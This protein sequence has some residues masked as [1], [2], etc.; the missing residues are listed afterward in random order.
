MKYMF[1]K[2]AL[3]TAAM[4][5][6]SREASAA[7]AASPFRTPVR[8][9]Y[10]M[11]VRQFQS[12]LNCHLMDSSNIAI[13]YKISYDFS[14]QS[15]DYRNWSPSAKQ[16]LGQ[17]F[18][19]TILWYESGMNNYPGPLVQDPPPN[20]EASA[21]AAGTHATTVYDN[22]TAL[23]PLYVGRVALILAAEIS[24][25]VPWSIKTFEAM[26]DGNN[27]MAKLFRTGHTGKSY[28]LNGTL[29]SVGTGYMDSITPTNSITIFKFL[30]QKGLL[31]NTPRQTI[32]RVLNW[33]RW[34]QAHTF[35]PL[36]G[37]HMYHYFQHWGDPPMSRMLQGTLSTDPAIPLEFRTNVYNWTHGCYGT[38]DFLVRL[39][40]AANIPA[41]TILAG[42]HRS[43][44]FMTESLFLSHADD[45]YTSMFKYNRPAGDL[46]IDAATF[47]AWFPVNNYSFANNN[48]GRQVMEI[49]IQY[50]SP[51]LLNVFKQDLLEGKTHATG[52]VYQYY[53]NWYTVEQLEAKGLWQKMEAALGWW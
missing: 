1:L 39:L 10:L 51:E 47:A 34:N 3:F 44:N 35:G 41:D 14:G 7:P 48:V 28:W 4:G 16:E 19:R 29:I 27:M 45:P 24:A 18:E 46:F 30:K 12:A 11:Q 42:S 50:P 22:A 40:K 31:G 15:L 26:P 20:L 13:A 49:N 37:A 53:K 23:W 21:F 36:G 38:S 32:E 6:L 17:A 43:V 5:A 25:W 33:S 8:C 2:A 52:N 9:A